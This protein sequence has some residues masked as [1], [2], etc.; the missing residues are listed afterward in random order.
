MGEATRGAAIR[1]VIG[2]ESHSTFA[3]FIVWANS[4]L[5]LGG[6]IGI[7]RSSLEGFGRALPGDDVVVI[8]R[9]ATRLLFRT[10]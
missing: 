6:R 7:T 2:M 9:P 5:R 8:E 3:E 10:C 4:G 1:R